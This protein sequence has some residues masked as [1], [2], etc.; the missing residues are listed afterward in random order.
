MSHHF[1]MKNS[2]IFREG[3][4]PLPRPHP[5]AAYGASVLASSALDLRPPDVPV[6]LTPMRLAAA[7]AAAAAEVELFWRRSL[8]SATIVRRFVYLLRLPKGRFL[9]QARKVAV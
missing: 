2:K 3:E 7:A 8:T 4:R 1:E 5:V 6:A 9:Y